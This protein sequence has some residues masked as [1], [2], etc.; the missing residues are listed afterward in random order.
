MSDVTY[1]QVWWYTQHMWP[2]PIW[3]PILGIRALHLPIQ[4]HTHTHTTHTH[5]NTRGAVGSH[6]C[7]GTQGAVGGLVPCSH[8]HTHTH[9]EQWAALYAAAPREQLGVWCLA[10]TH[11]HTHT[12]QWAALYAAAPREQ[13]GVW[14]LAQGHHVMVLKV[15]RAL[16]IHSPH[17][18]S[19]PDRDSN[20]QPFNYESDFLPLGHDFRMMRD[21]YHVS[22]QTM[23]YIEECVKGLGVTRM[24]G[25]FLKGKYC[26]HVDCWLNHCNVETLFQSIIHWLLY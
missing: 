1:S 10:L 12:E 4:V 5:T 24:E 13:L 19:L 25:Q 21:I 18:Q 7:C 6:L 14:C 16:C 20:S 8:T 17:Q 9:T 15:E 3:W 23:I 26:H 22:I 2:I 11:T